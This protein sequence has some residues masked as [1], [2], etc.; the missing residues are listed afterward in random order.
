MKQ[1]TLVF[2]S[3][4]PEGVFNFHIKQRYEYDDNKIVVHKHMEKV[5][6]VWDGYIKFSNGTLF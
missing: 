2:K 5:Y 3:S 1:D 4:S 6:G